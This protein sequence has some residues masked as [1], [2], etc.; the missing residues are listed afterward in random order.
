MIVPDPLSWAFAN[1]IQHFAALDADY[2][3]QVHLVEA[4]QKEN[5]NLKEQIKKLTDALRLANAKADEL[6]RQLDAAKAE[7]EAA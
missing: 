1:H 4:L 7:A 6:Q 3:V 5:I 2:H